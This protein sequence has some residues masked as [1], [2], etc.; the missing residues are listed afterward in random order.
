MEGESIYNKTVTV[1][2]LD[3]W[4]TLENRDHRVTQHRSFSAH[5]L[6]NNQQ[7]KVVRGR[8]GSWRG[9]EGS[10]LTNPFILLNYANLTHIIYNVNT[11]SCRSII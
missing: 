6:L 9:G 10:W 7:D 5:F 11:V 4:Q 2:C 1:C 3:C 8:D